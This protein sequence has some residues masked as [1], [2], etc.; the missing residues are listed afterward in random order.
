MVEGRFIELNFLNNLFIKLLYI[1]IMATITNKR[2]LFLGV[3]IMIC[4][5]FY[6]ATSTIVINYYNGN[7]KT[8]LY[9]GLG[10]GCLL[11]L[12]S[13]YPIYQS[14]QVLKLEKSDIKAPLLII[15][16]CVVSYIST[17]ALVLN[18]YENDDVYKKKFMITNIII[19]CLL[20]LIMIYPTYHL[21][22]S[23]PK[24]DSIS[25]P[26]TKQFVMSKNDLELYN[27]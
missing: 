7:T 22:N 12:L 18:K 1:F 11:I 24:M 27:R 14:T 17:S 13:L 6:I 10:L 9:V 5:I 26:T 2:L 25:A 20:L 23:Q 21:I 16:I 4:S 19:G 3:F 15:F 8:G